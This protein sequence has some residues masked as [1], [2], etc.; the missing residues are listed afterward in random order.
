MVSQE[1]CL[2]S[3]CPREGSLCQHGSQGGCLRQRGPQVGCQNSTGPKK[4]VHG[5]SMDLTKIPVGLHT[6]M[7][8]MKAFHT[9]MGPRKAYISIA[10]RKAFS[11]ATAPA[12]P[13]CPDKGVE[14]SFP[15]CALCPMRGESSRLGMRLWADA[16][17][18][19][20]PQLWRLPESSCI[21]TAPQ[22]P[23]TYTPITATF[24][25]HRSNKPQTAALSLPPSSPA[26]QPAW[27]LYPLVFSLH[28]F[29]AVAF[30]REWAWELVKYRY[31]R[32]VPSEN[33]HFYMKPR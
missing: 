28:S 27:T 4:A 18:S 21:N 3:H 31:W 22:C 30:L 7:V 10:L 14:T 8:P 20:P 13:H 11:T 17:H 26:A 6:N 16:M 24:K 1:G 2:Y 19:K 12:P 23:E 25:R 9:R 29:L 5:S 15:S 33:T 32:V